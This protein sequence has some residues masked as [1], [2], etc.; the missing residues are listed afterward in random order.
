M[1]IQFPNSNDEIGPEFII[2]KW[3]YQDQV[4]LCGF[5]Y[6]EPILAQRVIMVQSAGVRAARK[7]ENV[8]KFGAS[9][10][11]MIL[12]LITECREEGFFNLGH[13]YSATL[14]KMQLSG[15]MKAHALIEDAQLSWSRGEGDMAKHMITAVIAENKPTF[16]HAKAL[17]M[18]GEYLADARLEDTNTIIQTYFSKSVSFSTNI[19]KSEH[20]PVGSA[21][22]YSPEDRQRLDLENRKRNYQAI[23]KCKLNFV[24]IFPL[25]VHKIIRFHIKLDVVQFQMRIASI[26]KLL[27]TK[28]PLNLRKNWQTS[29]ET[30][31]S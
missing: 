14:H 7:I 6:R 22:Y 1:K 26:N 27:H 17:W 24:F 19:K 15:E 10:Q 2:N 29:S 18:M 23:A 16:T 20:I 9:L 30:K 5:N 21:Y 28:N 3:N 4:S 13:R 31:R 8:G 12:N 11:Q 25:K